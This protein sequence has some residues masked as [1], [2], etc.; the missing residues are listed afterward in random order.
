MDACSMTPADFNDWMGRLGLSNLAAS[1]TL[2]TSKDTTPKYA[3]GTAKIP[4]YIALA[5]AAIEAGLEPIGGDN[6]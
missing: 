5:C 2:G 1:R 3:K 4:R 6:Q